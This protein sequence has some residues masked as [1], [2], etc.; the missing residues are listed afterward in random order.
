[1]SRPLVPARIG[2]LARWVLAAFGWTVDVAWPPVPRCVIVVYPHTSN[3]DFALGYLAKLATGLPVHWIGK[4][5]LFRWPV[6]GL[7]RRM[8]GIPV[9]RRERTGLTERLAAELRGRPRMWLALAPEGTR[10]RTDHWK[11]GFYRLALAAGVPVGLAFIDYRAKVVGLR[12]Y[13]TLTGDVERDLA[14]VRAVYAGKVGRHPEQA[15]EIRL[16]RD[17]DP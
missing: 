7:L 16:L 9:N 8:G 3:W 13:L 6:A 4:D 17:R 15:G 14:R 12:T 10:A 11:S 1:M 2:R 5:T